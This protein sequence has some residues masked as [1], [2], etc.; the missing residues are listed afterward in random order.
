[1]SWFFFLK[2]GR[3]PLDVNDSLRWKPSQD[4][5]DLDAPTS[6]LYAPPTVESPR[7]RS[8]LDADAA[9]ATPA[10]GAARSGRAKTIS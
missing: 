1:M 10:A 4:M 6:P 9:P 7:R 5:A 8:S 3:I 2:F